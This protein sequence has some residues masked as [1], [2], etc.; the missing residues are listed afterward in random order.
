MFNECGLTLPTATRWIIGVSQ[1]LREW[2][3]ASLFVGSVLIVASFVLLRHGFLQRSFQQ[4]WGW[5]VGTLGRG[6]LL[7]GLAKWS[8]HVSTLMETGMAQ[9]DAIEIAGRA[10]HH[11]GIELRSQHW[12]A[13]LPIG[14]LSIRGFASHQQRAMQFVG[15]CPA[16]FRTVV[17]K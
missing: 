17:S 15:F 8:R 5:S 3:A 6:S 1:F 4:H 13:S 14:G 11:A 7:S 12:S 16:A 10:T 2:G 9:A